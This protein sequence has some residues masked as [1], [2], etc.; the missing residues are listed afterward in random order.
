PIPW[1]ETHEKALIKAET[2]KPDRLRQVWFAGAHADVGG[3]YPDDGLS[4]VPLGWMIGEASESEKG[5]RFIPSIV[6]EF[7]ALANPTGRVYDP[8]S[9]FGALYRY[10]PRDAQKLLGKGNTPI[11]AG[12][13]M[14]RIASGTEGYAPISLPE[15]IEV[16]PPFGPPVA[17][18]PHA[19]K[20]ALT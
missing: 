9:G 8:R 10:Q 13:V 20:A 3:G 7:A 12:S 16:L 18:T 19:V 6:A 5:L 4:L 17:F 14:T 11:V 1:D 15:K 2:V